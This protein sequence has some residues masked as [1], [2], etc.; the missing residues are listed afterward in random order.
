MAPDP[1]VEVL[2]EQYAAP[3]HAANEQVVG[4]LSGAQGGHER[5]EWGD[6]GQLHPVRLNPIVWS[7]SLDIF[8]ARHQHRAHATYTH[9]TTPPTQI[10][11]AP[12]WYSWRA[13]LTSST[14]MRSA[15]IHHPRNK[16]P[17]SPSTMVQAPRW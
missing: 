5:W 11:Q 8:S 1:E 14:A 6:R 17:P 2:L 16:L 3:V 10:M 13:I 7:F 15:P 12:P 4:E 9:L